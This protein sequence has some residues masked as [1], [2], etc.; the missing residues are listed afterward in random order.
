MP[1]DVAAPPSPFDL[2]PVTTQYGEPSAF[3]GAPHPG[4]DIG[5]NTGTPI[6]AF[7]G[8][9]VSRIFQDSVGGLQVIVTTPEGFQEVYAHLAATAVHPGDTVGA[10]DFIGWSGATGHVT[11]PHLHYEVRNPNGTTLDPRDFLAEFANAI[12]GGGGPPAATSPSSSGGPKPSNASLSSAPAVDPVKCGMILTF[13]ALPR[14]ALA[15]LT[16]IPEA[17]LQAYAYACGTAAGQ[18]SGVEALVAGAGDFL[19][20]PASWA[21]IGFTIVGV[22]L[23]GAGALMYVKAMK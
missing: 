18:K 5:V 1:P 17:E 12:T 9:T 16:G 8:G 23:I 7:I 19:F 2:G 20:N 10:S 22:L 11:G 15:T 14:P 4:V 21:K 13:S 3:T 6:P